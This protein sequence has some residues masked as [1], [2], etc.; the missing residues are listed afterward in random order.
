MGRL[1]RSGMLGAALLGGGVALAQP[2]PGGAGGRGVFEAWDANRDGRV[3]WDEAWAQVQRH[4]AGADANHDN[5]LSMQEWLAA[6]LPGRPPLPN[7][8]PPDAQRQSDR[9]QAMFRAI[10]ANRDNLVT[11]EEIRP[12]AESWFRAFDANADGAITAEEA[13]RPRPAGPR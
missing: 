12:V 6:R 9:R 10:D 4:F 2:G 11:L 8:P 3:T 1:L 5:A 7:R 13:P